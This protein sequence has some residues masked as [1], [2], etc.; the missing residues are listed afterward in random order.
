MSKEL[1]AKFVVHLGGDSK[2]Q[3]GRFPNFDGPVQV[4]LNVALPGLRLT[5][6]HNLAI[7]DQLQLLKTDSTGSRC[8]HAHLTP[9]WELDCTSDVLAFDAQAKQR[10]VTDKRPS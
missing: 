9:A 3:P 4:R 2:R 8:L 6:K 7:L 5:L 1:T 10:P